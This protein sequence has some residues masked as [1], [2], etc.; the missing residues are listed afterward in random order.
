MRSAMRA[1]SHAWQISHHEK[2]E[3]KLWFFEKSRIYDNTK[4]V[5]NA[6]KLMRL[7]GFKCTIFARTVTFHVPGEF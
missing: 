2:M 5:W 3:N 6:A 7:T 4:K 1:A